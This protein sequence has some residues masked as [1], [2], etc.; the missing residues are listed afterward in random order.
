ME[1]KTWPYGTTRRA[2]VEMVRFHP[3]ELAVEASDGQLLVDELGE[4]HICVGEQC[5]DFTASEGDLGTL[6][7]T[8]GGPTGGYWRFVKD[9]ATP[10]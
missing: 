7:F 9:T 6:T 3:R 10:Q 4:M 5:A 1:T 8:Q 2:K